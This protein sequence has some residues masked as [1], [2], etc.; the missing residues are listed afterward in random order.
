M[1]TQWNLSRN[2]QVFG[3]VTDLQLRQTVASGRVLPTDLLNEA[4][5]PDWIAANTVPGLFAP[6]ISVEDPVVAELIEEPVAALRVIR[7]TCFGCFREVAIEV[8]PG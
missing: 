7:V 4:G 5:K 2:G 1:E 3:P 8:T 6:L